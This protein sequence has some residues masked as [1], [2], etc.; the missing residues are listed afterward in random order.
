MIGDGEPGLTSE[1]GVM[2]QEQARCKV[3]CEWT[4][5]RLCVA[6]G[7]LAEAEGLDRSKRL[8]LTL[9]DC[10]YRCGWCTSSAAFWV[11]KLVQ[12]ARSM[13]A[14]ASPL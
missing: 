9:A 2:D 12:T 4:W 3:E 14:E 6:K 13:L 10:F 1:K 8:D 5:P 11:V 7:D